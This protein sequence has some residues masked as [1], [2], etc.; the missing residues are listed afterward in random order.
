MRR[1]NVWLAAAAWVTLAT[2][3]RSIPTAQL[4]VVVDTNLTAADGLTDIY[5]EARSPDG[6]IQQ[7]RVFDLAPRGTLTLPLSFGVVPVG[8][9]LRRRVRVIAQARDSSGT[10]LVQRSALAGFFPDT[11]LRLPLFLPNI[12]RGLECPSGYTCRG[13]A[14]VCVPDEVRTEA[15]DRVGP[16]PDGGELDGSTTLPFASDASLSLDAS[17]DASAPRDSAR[18]AAMPDVAVFDAPPDACVN[19]VERS[20]LAPTAVPPM[21]PRSIAPLAGSVVSGARPTLR[22]EP[23]AGASSYD[24]Q[25]CRDRAMS[26]GCVSSSSTPA[27]W[28]PTSDFARGLWFWRARAVVGGAPGP[29]GLLWSFVARAGGDGRAWPGRL[30]LDGDGFEDLV[31]GGVEF[32]SAVNGSGSIRVIY[33]GFSP[34]SPPTTAVVW[35]RGACSDEA[36]ARALASAGDVNGD[37]YSDVVAGAGSIGGRGLPGAAR[38]FYGGASRVTATA[39]APQVFADADAT[40]RFG[41]SVAGV[42][43]VNGDGYSD[44]AIGSPGTG[45]TPPAGQ[46]SIF[47]GGPA[48]LARAPALVLSGSTPGD[49]FGETVAGVGDVN[50]DGYSDVA[51]AAPNEAGNGVVRLFLGSATGLSAT[52]AQTFNGTNA[53]WRFGVAIVGAFDADR[54]GWPDLAMGAPSSRG[55]GA[56]NAAGEVVVYR[57]RA[58]AAGAVFEPTG[59]RFTRVTGEPYAWGFSL[60]AGDYNGDGFDDLAVGAAGTDNASFGRTEGSA[61]AVFEGGASG[62]SN[63][64]AIFLTAAQQAGY[65]E[66]LSARDLN[67]DGFT[68]LLV[69]INSGANAAGRVGFFFGAATGVPMTATSGYQS[70]ASGSTLDGFGRPIAHFVATGAQGLVKGPG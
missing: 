40:R 28:S 2:G 69:S 11:A 45:T 16:R 1:S 36:I 67:N 58:G 46:A 7:Q 12:C 41:A 50:G 49:G 60:S 29:Y 4:V 54:D 18:E 43:D 3:C 57:N 39:I 6:T 30:D 44:V 59:Q 70:R 32:N 35:A 53:R 22:W 62:L 21:A 42:G 63:T 38:V 15:L 47:H 64:R 68:D 56:T 65:G 48:G 33:G 26:A 24:V 23:V 61:V 51:I 20:T 17:L 31:V 9:D 66:G 10:V 5:V 34:A 27:Q 13:D 25:L 55:A 52:S 19:A 8:G 37:G 14:P